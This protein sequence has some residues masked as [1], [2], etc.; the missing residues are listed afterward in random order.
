MKFVEKTETHF[1]QCSLMY[2]SYSFAKCH[3]TEVELVWLRFSIS[4]LRNNFNRQ[5]INFVNICGIV[6]VS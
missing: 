4:H 6:V 1:T 3:T 2:M 5:I